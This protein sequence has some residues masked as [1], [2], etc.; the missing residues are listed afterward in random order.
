MSYQTNQELKVQFS[1]SVHSQ[2]WEIRTFLDWIATAEIVH[3][4]IRF[5]RHSN[6][7]HFKGLKL[8]SRHKEIFMMS[9]TWYL[10]S[11]IQSFHHNFCQTTIKTLNFQLKNRFHN[12]LTKA[13]L[14]QDVQILMWRNI[15]TNTNAKH[16]TSQTIFHPRQRTPSKTNYH[17]IF[18]KE[19][20]QQI[21]L[22]WII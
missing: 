5:Y 8:K 7:L 15:W 18:T 4:T 11:W 10:M 13:I 6:K 14:D 2:I 21:W 3:S 22:I 20:S 12:K 9:Q 17:T 19:K 1:S 16:L